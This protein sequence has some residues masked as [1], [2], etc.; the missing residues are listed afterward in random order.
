MLE[1]PHYGQELRDDYECDDLRD[2]WL[3]DPPK[4]PR[5]EG[6]EVSGCPDLDENLCQAILHGY[7]EYWEAETNWACASDCLD[8]AGADD[9]TANAVG[10]TASCEC[11]YIWIED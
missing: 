2:D 9:Y 7:Y 5:F 1:P 3:Q 6:W 10:C 8:L 4:P 11:D